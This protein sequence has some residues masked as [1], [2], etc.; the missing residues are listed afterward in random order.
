MVMYVGCVVEKCASDELFRRRLHPY[1]KGL[2]SA[3]PVPNIHLKREQTI[4]Q[5][6]LTSPVEP[7]PGCRFVNRCPHAKERCRTE[8]PVL[9]EVLPAHFVACHY[10]REIN[11]L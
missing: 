10:V 3:I 4:M 9:E 8:N 2:I 7:K 1:T 6:E 5:G 11:Q